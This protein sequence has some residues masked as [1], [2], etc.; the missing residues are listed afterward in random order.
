MEGTLWARAAYQS[1][2][3]SFFTSRV[4]STLHTQ[5]H[6]HMHALSQLN[7]MSQRSVELICNLLSFA[8]LSKSHDRSRIIFRPSLLTN[9]TRLPQT[10]LVF[11]LPLCASS[12]SSHVFIYVSESDD[13]RVIAV[14]MRTTQTG[15]CLENMYVCIYIY[16]CLFFRIQGIYACGAPSLSG[17]RGVSDCG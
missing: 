13:R 3:H 12:A 15:W 5:T 6:T 2:T 11:P 9:I 1:H 16:I 4:L 14:C 7:F 17:S 8:V 10:L